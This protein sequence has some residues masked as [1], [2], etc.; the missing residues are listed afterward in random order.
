MDL[1][2]E[3]SNTRCALSTDMK[4]KIRLFRLLI[5]NKLIIDYD[6]HHHRFFRNNKESLM[7][8]VNAN[9]KDSQEMP[10]K[11]QQQQNSLQFCLAN[12]DFF[13]YTHTDTKTNME[14]KS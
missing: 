5:R 13:S 3:H 14:I 10:Q 9:E 4:I 8:K 1:F 6:H 7:I 2:F 12:D 11:N